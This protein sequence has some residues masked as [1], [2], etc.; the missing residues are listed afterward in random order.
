[1]Q[2][3]A[4]P[5]YTQL[6]PK[7]PKILWWFLRSLVLV[8]TLSIVVLLFTE[9]E[10]ALVL[11]WQILIPLLPLGFAL[12]PGL[13]RNICPLAL[14]NQ[15]P[16]QFGFSR[17]YNLP[18]NWRRFALYL[19][20]IAFVAF[21]LCRQPWL[22]S[23]A[24]LLGTV[25]I[26]ALILAFIGGVVFKG[27]SGW[28]G[29][30]CPLAPIQKAYGH[31]PIF[32]VRNGYCERCLGC[33]KN[34]YDFNPRAAFFTDIED[35]DSSWSD[36]RKF[37]LGILPGLIIAFF[38]T[39]FSTDNQILPYLQSM[40]LPPLISA[41]L[42]Y[43][44]YNL[45]HINFF[46]LASF[47]AM[48]SLG[49]FYWYALPGMVSGVQTLTGFQV[50]H[51]VIQVMQATVVASCVLVF[52][53]ALVSERQFNMAKQSSSRASIGEGVEVLKSALQ[54]TSSL[55]LVEEQSS[56]Q[57]LTVQTGQSLLDAIEANELPIISGC[58]MGMCG[59]DPVIITA[60]FENLEPPDE[61]E[62]NTLKRLGLEGKARLACCCRPKAGISIDLD[63]DPTQYTAF[64]RDI[65]TT[66]QVGDENRQKILIVG[67][68]IAG[69]STAESLRDAN[70]ECSITIISNEPYH[71]YNRM[72][73]EA[74][75]YGR[76][77]MQNLYLIKEEW[78]G[79]N[80]IETWL[81]TKVVEIDV[82]SHCIKLGTGESVDFDQLVIATGA[83]AY[84][85]E[86]NFYHLPGVY[87]LRNAEDALTIRHWVQETKGKRA[88]VI[89]GGVLGIEAAEALTQMGL[90]VTIV[91]TGER[92]M[93][94]QLDLHSAVILK[95][96]L[97]NKG[98]RVLTSS[99]VASI[100]ESNSLLSVVL[101]DD[102]ALV[103][104]LVLLCIGVRAETELA[105]SA[106]L[107]I[108]RGIIVDEQMR[109][110]NN[111]IYCVGD[112]AELP[113]AV[114]G[115]WSVASEQGK[116]AA[117]AILQGNKH[118][119]LASLPSVQLKVNGIDL[120]C[121]GSFDEND[122]YE[123]FSGGDI[124]RHTWR[125]LRI[126]SGKLVA[127]VFVNSPLTAAAAFAVLKRGGKLIQA[128]I[129]AILGKDDV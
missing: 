4:F 13:W 18:D 45:L 55:V 56:G 41:G 81:N 65:S 106:G 22:N 78:Y 23:N 16:R 42:F 123:S 82:D 20:V 128:D 10:I 75:L 115:L 94:R 120:K 59:S 57:Q 19:S 6:K 35:S 50:P 107:D 1:M 74:V 79:L 114:G 44:V 127:G 32:L 103:C 102:R 53:R 60:G 46:K 91:H 83:K 25:L 95:T 99:S 68:G 101:D 87:V 17:E 21:I 40:L 63:A 69:M 11:V 119:S 30:F 12:I 70:S 96:F 58:R 100:T 14:L 66:R 90:N 8:I 39:N 31:A 33:Q 37:F 52:A 27:R 34:C 36:Q 7:F 80:R 124:S 129:E 85:P 108:N 43:S 2:D 29:T 73:L 111:D 104:G 84:V 121:F 109:T 9:A 48:T 97:G 117:S 26:A 47:S 77:A 62:T 118:Y 88:T 112:A 5:N 76:T 54:Q 105:K 38:S 67:N 72:G 64:S 89:G 15:I 113:G 126:N 86:E 116:I 28:C 24:T 125:H 98:I 110:S 93:N 49:L 92:L 71:F 51:L 122:K 61:N 3:E